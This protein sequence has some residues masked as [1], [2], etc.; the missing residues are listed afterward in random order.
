MKKGTI[1]KFKNKNQKSNFIR[2]RLG[3]KLTE[4]VS[5]F[6][7]STKEDKRMATIDEMVDQAH[8]LMLAKQ[9]IIP[10]EDAKRIIA[11]LIEIGEKLKNNELEIDLDSLDIHPF[12]EQC[13]IEKCDNSLAV[14]GKMHTAKSRN[15]QVERICEY[16]S[17]GK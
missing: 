11:A 10:S 6:I 12:I 5:S 1:V 8:N 16:I 3:N 4:E 13:V 17:E 9:G 2:G 14:G 7:G 15:D